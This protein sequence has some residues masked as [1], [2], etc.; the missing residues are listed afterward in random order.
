MSL[1]QIQK[2]EMIVIYTNILSLSNSELK[3]F[4]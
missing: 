4:L 2:I 1:I 3:F